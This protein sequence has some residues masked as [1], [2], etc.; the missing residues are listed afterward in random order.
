[1]LLLVSTC[2]FALPAAA[3]SVN[4]FCVPLPKPCDIGNLVVL[5][6]SAGVSEFQSA[7]NVVILNGDASI[8]GRVHGTV[9]AL[10]GDVAVSGHVDHDV[11]AL[12]GT[13]VVTPPLQ[14]GA[15]GERVQSGYVGGDVVSRKKATI[16]KGAIVQGSVDRVEGRFALGQLAWVGRIVLWIALTVSVLLLGAAL[17]VVAPRMLEATAAIGR[18]AIGP[19][20]GLGFAAGIGVPVVGGL[21]LVTIIGLPLGLLMLLALGLFYAFGYTVSAFFLGRLILPAKS[22][23]LAFV[24]GWAI[25]RVADLV[26]VLG[27]LVGLAAMIYGVGMVTVAVMRARQPDSTAVETV[28]VS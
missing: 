16:S 14:E 9:F 24:V 22:P 1:L 25:L 21:L 19:A 4:G 12:N 3:R 2:T 6:G 15:L 13:V 11:V 18:T 10:N 7:D 26:P 17:I 27:T 20:I 5:T 28:S 23:W 8:Q